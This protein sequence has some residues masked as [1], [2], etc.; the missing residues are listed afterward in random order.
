MLRKRS[1]IWISI[2][3]A[4]LYK[5]QISKTCLVGTNLCTLVVDIPVKHERPLCKALSVYLGPTTANRLSDAGVTYSRHNI[6]LTKYGLALYFCSLKPVL[7]AIF[8]SFSRQ[9][10]PETR[11]EIGLRKESSS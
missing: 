3:T 5:S 4:Q 8:L 2:C 1:L 10:I 6:T 7:Y 11:I 9:Q